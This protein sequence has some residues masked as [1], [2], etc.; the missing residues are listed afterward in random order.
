MLLS[1]TDTQSHTFRISQPP[2]TVLPSFLKLIWS[3][4]TINLQSNRLTYQRLLSHPFLELIP[5]NV[6]L[7]LL[8]YSFWATK[9]T[10]KVSAH[11]RR[12]CKSFVISLNPLPSI[13]FMSFCDSAGLSFLE[14]C[15]AGG[16]L[17]LQCLKH[18]S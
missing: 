17:Q 15:A 3:T 7:E 1:L 5:L 14:K 6:C 16:R 18:L 2:C 12:K 13:N 9:W 8:S 11:S 10:A 4:H